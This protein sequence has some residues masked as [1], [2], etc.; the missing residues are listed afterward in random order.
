[1]ARRTFYA[2]FSNGLNIKRTSESRI[3]THAYLIVTVTKSGEER[4]TTGF[5]STKKGAEKALVA[6]FPKHYN[7]QTGKWVKNKDLGHKLSEVVKTTE[8]QQG[9]AA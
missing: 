5:S 6:E 2:T 4:Y 8:K 3:Y 1:M 9:G 7:P